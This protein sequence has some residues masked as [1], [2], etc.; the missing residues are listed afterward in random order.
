MNS[1]NV[2]SLPIVKNIKNCSDQDY[3]TNITNLAQT[4]TEQI[5]YQKVHNTPID[6]DQATINQFTVLSISNLFN[7]HKNQVIEDLN[8]EI[9]S[10]LI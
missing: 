2:R 9:R 7:I 3:P 8:R 6:V 10:Q 5:K 1:T 4:I